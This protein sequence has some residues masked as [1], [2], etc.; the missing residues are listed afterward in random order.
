[1]LEEMVRDIIEKFSSQF[2]NTGELSRLN[3]DS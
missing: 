1:M 2:L 3:T